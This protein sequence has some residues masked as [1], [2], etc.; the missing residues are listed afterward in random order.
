MKIAGI[1]LQRNEIDVVLFN[2]LYHLGIVGFDKLI[3]GD[4]GSTDGSKE[5]L[6]RL[7]KREPRLTVLDMAGDYQQ[8]IR[9]NEMY[10]LA[11]AD[12]A[13]WVVPLD[14]D[15][16]LPTNRRTLEAILLDT[17]EAA[18]RLNV[19]NFVQNRRVTTRRMNSIASIFLCAKPSGSPKEA[20]DLVNSG[21]IG[22]VEMAYPPKY[23]WRADKGLVI[24]KGNHGANISLQG[25]SKSVV[26]NH[27]PLRSKAAIAERIERIERLESKNPTTSWHIRRLV[28]VD[29]SEEWDRNSAKA[30]AIDVN[31]NRHRLAFDP[32]FWRIFLRYALT[33]RG[34]ARDLQPR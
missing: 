6:L 33:V 15:E 7:G 19:R 3:V 24:A 12:G 9:V 17:S 11:V 8:A 2:A 13:D 20:Y 28:N 16:F 31:G 34:L 14:A 1:I 18:V 5:A 10:Q 29:I 30:G 32:F 27:V 25:I 21:R 26:L 23:L 4:N 22:F